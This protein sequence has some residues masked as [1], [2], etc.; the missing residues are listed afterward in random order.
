[1]GV[2]KLHADRWAKTYL[3]VD[4]EAGVASYVDPGGTPS[5]LPFALSNHVGSSCCTPSLPTRMRT[6][7]R[8]ASPCESERGA[9]T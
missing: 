8:L 2:E 6:T 3:I 4:E 7:S 9:T 5:M 1:M